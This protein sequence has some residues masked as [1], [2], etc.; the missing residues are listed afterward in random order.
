MKRNHNAPEALYARR[1]A[2]RNQV[3][4]AESPEERKPLLKRLR[5]VE[6]LIRQIRG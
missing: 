5:H 6:Q 3:H 4:T 1:D 2:L